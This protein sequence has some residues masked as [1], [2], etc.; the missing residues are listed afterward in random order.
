MQ[1]CCQAGNNSR[2]E[3]ETQMPVEKR[4]INE[5]DKLKRK[6]KILRTAWYL[7]EQ[8][9]GQLPTV[10]VIARASGLSKGSVY[11][12]FKTKSEIFLNL[13]IHQIKAWHLSVE[14]KLKK[15]GD[16]ISIEE[17]A[18]LTAEYLVKKPLLLTLGSMV[19]G[20]LEK[21]ADKA[22]ILELKMELARVLSRRSQMTARLF[23]G[24]EI[25]EWM[26]I[27]LRIYA[28][29]F[30]LWQMYYSSPQIHQV[31]GDKETGLF[32]SDFYKSARDSVTVFLKGALNPDA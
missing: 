16:Q 9:D 8:N 10:S 19:A 22:V 20:E 24:L 13:Y 6:D 4:A 31:L 11:L 23:P 12:Y 5:K 2:D 17:Y 28:L 18:A 30:G 3:K 32:E 1:R 21:N 7:F 14:K 27:H 25:K 26:N 29:I 15:A